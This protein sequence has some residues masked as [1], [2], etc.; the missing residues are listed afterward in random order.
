MD[1][2]LLLMHIQ[3]RVSELY[4]LVA[5]LEALDQQIQGSNGGL[6]GPACWMEWVMKK[7]VD[8]P[9]IASSPDGLRL[10]AQ[11]SHQVQA[12]ERI[13]HI[14]LTGCHRT[15]MTVDYYLNQPYSPHVSK[16]HDAG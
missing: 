5:A 12:R 8:G 11:V 16:V 1:Q 13:G 14:E 10:L 3:C 15:L 6:K 7:Y 2:P 4:R 9:S